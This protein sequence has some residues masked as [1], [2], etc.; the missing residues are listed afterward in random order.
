MREE[1]I[2]VWDYSLRKEVRGV[3]VYAVIIRVKIQIGC[4]EYAESY[5]CD[6]CEEWKYTTTQLHDSDYTADA[7]RLRDENTIY[8]GWN[9]FAVAAKRYRY[10][11]INDV[12]NKHMWCFYREDVLQ[13]L[14]VNILLL[15]SF[16]LLVVVSFCL[17]CASV[18]TRSTQ[19]VRIDHALF[20]VIGIL[21]VAGFF[22]S[23][24]MYIEK[25]G[26]LLF[27]TGVLM[28]SCALLALTVVTKK[29]VFLIGITL[30][31]SALYIFLPIASPSPVIDVFVA[32]QH[33]A[34]HLLN[35]RNPYVYPVPDVYEQGFNVPGYVYL[36]TNLLLP[37]ISYALHGDVRY[38]FVV[39]LLASAFLLRR[40][41]QKNGLPRLVPE[42]LALCFL[43]S[44]RNL[45][46]LEQSWVEPVMVLLLFAFVLLVQQKPKSML[47]IV[48]FGLF[49]ST[50]QYLLFFPVHAFLFWKTWWK[51]ALAVCIALLTALPFVLMDF[52]S[53]WE[54]GV[55]YVLSGVFRHDS[56]TIP[57]FV[58]HTFGIEFSGMWTLIVGA[59]C[60]VLTYFLFR[61]LDRLQGFLLTATITL[62]AMF[63]FGAQGFCNYYFVVQGLILMCVGAPPRCNFNE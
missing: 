28:A 35:G 53:F 6:C 5:D 22:Q 52:S 41:A 34:E 7:I 1:E 3:Q 12:L 45:F 56:L 60:A 46:V 62:F 13:F 44:P 33:A 17:L 11:T 8:C 63:L 10:A 59:V 31:F 36:P 20:L 26:Y 2:S 58:Y 32:E 24:G 61:R 30:L 37:T 39:A 47:A 40:L 50:K 16:T 4:F 18:W 43:A 48:L 51:I 25:A 49:L 15:G 38:A 42:L 14:P 9:I 23:P 19:R 55:M 57:S 29:R 54:S 21:L 27:Y